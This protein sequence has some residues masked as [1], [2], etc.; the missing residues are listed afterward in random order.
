MGTVPNWPQS[1][2]CRARTLKG[3]VVN[4]HGR[5][6]RWLGQHLHEGW[7]SS[8]LTQ[9]GYIR[10]LSQ[11]AYPNRAPAAEV[12]A[13]LTKA[14]RLRRYRARKP[15]TGWCWKRPSPEAV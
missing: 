3:I 6:T 14:S 11:T 15:R 9:N 8:P 10:I 12:A 5:A 4:H 1:T 2:R 13:R 7:A